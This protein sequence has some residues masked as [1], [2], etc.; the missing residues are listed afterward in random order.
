[1]GAARGPHRIIPDP[2]RRD[3]T[4]RIVRAAVTASQR[5]IDTVLDTFPTPS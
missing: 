5:R 2:P 3:R 4:A 1:M